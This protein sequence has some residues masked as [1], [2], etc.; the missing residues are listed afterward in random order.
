VAREDGR[1][2]VDTYVIC[3]ADGLTPIG[4]WQSLHLHAPDTMPTAPSLAAARE[5]FRELARGT[6]RDGIPTDDGGPWA[7]VVPADSWDGITYAVDGAYRLTVGPRGGIR[8]EY[9]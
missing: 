6:Y 2:I 5:T 8:A 9:V 4:A 3:Y 7:D 1:E